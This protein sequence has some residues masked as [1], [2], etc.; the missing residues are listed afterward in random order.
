MAE[1]RSGYGRSWK[2]WLAIYVLAGA[3]VY[4]IAYVLFFTDGSSGGGG[5]L[6]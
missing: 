4:L 6:Y 3:I 1:K 2:Q 5:G